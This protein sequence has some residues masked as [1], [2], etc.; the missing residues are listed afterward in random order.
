MQFLDS[1]SLDVRGGWWGPSRIC[2]TELN[3]HDF[4]V[5][6][7]KLLKIIQNCAPQACEIFSHTCPEI[8]LRDPP[9]VRG[10][11]GVPQNLC[12]GDLESKNCEDEHPMNR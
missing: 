6:P 12:N 9:D 5:T 11:G 2:V 7:A 8:L 3:L 1:K 10:G 4:C